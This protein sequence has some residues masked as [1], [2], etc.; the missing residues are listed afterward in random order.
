MARIRTIKPEFWTSEQVVECS[1][2]ARLLFIGMWNFCDDDGNHPASAKS[3][4]MQVFPGDDIS[5]SDIDAMLS[6]LSENGLIIEYAAGGKKY[7]HVTGWHHQKIEKPAYKYPKFSDQSATSRRPVDDQSP[8][9]LPPVDDQSPTA[10]PRKGCRRDVEGKVREFPPTPQGGD[11]DGI[12][13]GWKED[14]RKY[15]AMTLEWEPDPKTLEAYLSGKAANGRPVTAAD[16]RVWLPDWRQN[17]HA[18]GK[19][20]TDAQWTLRL[21]KYAMTCMTSDRAAPA[22]RRASA[23]QEDPLA[24]TEENRPK[25]GPYALFKPGPKKTPMTDEGRARVEQLRRQAFGDTA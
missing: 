12:P 4:K 25:H 9:I 23:P 24:F 6:E 13:A 3:I 18:G 10:T 7:W 16:V 21:V 14:S 5:T 11:E 20:M 8:T 1:P 15:S 17:A 22:S 19:T 2:I